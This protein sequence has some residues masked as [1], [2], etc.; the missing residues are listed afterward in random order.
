MTTIC[1]YLQAHQPVRL[2][3]FSVFDIGSGASYFDRERNLFYLERIVRK[4]YLPMTELL[5]ALAR[6]H[7]ARFAVNL[8]ITGVLLEALEEHFPSVLENI[9]KLIATGRAEL[10]AE[11]YYHSLAFLYSRPEFKAQVAE[12][13]RALRKQFKVRPRIFRHTEL[14]TSNELA[15]AVKAMRYRGLLA[16]GHDWLLGWRSPNMVYELKTAPGLPVLLRNYRLSDDVSFRF[17]AR[18]WREWPLT[19]DRFA[20]WVHGAAEDSQVVN[21]F[22]DFET[23]GEHQWPET[24]IFEFMRHLPAELARGGSAR[25]VTVS[26]AFKEFS[27]R[28]TLDMHH[29]TSWADVERDL[30]AWRGNKMQ[31]S[32]L[33]EL[34]ALEPNVLRSRDRTLIRDWRLLQTS[35][36]FYYM[37]TK[38]FADGDVHKYFNPYESP[39]EAYLTFMNIINDMKIRL[40]ERSGKGRRESNRT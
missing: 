28:G 15:R 11:T 23:F 19:A 22:M 5:L 20:S 34:Y 39:Y 3:R 37:C 17:S 2:R 31:E 16:E 6:E 21:L 12:H 38:W 24:G 30:S 7:G 14:A 36:H 25:F 4:S 26:E 29:M 10:L 8:G 1:F 27:P 32:A 9:R 18:S 33:R 13:A 40:E 35:D